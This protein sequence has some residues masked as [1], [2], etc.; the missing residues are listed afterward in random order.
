MPIFIL[1]S[2]HSPENCPLFNQK[3]RKVMMEAMN[4]SEG[5]MKKHRV[6]MLGTWAVPNEH[7]GYEVYEAPSL[8]AFEKLGMEP[9]IMAMGEFN[10]MEIKAATSYEE[11]AQMLKRTR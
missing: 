10:T 2:K 7:T 4:K 1:I 3:A 5:L 8:D 6:K 9:A 11:V